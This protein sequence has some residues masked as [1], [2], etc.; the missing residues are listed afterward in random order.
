MIGGDSGFAGG[1]IS[2]G[3]TSSATTAAIGSSLASSFN[4]DCAW[5]A[6]VALARKRSTNAVSRRRS[7]LLLLGELEIERLALA[8]LALEGGVAA[9][10]ERELA[11]FEMQDPVD[12]VVEQ[13][14]V[15]ADDDHRAR[16][17]RDVLLEPK[18]RLEVEIV[19][20]L[21][22]QQQIGLGEQHR[23]ER[24]AHAPA[25]GEFRASAALLG[26]GETQAGEDFGGARRRRMGPDI[27]EPGLDLGDAVGIVLGLGLGQQSR[28]LGV[29]LE[30]DI[31][32]AFGAIRRL[33]G[34]A[35][36]AGAQWKRDL[37]VLGRELAADD[38][39]Q[40]GLPRAVAADE[41]D[42]GAVRNPC[43][44]AVDQQPAGQAHREVVD[45]E[46]ARGCGRDRS[47]R[48]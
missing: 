25:A 24:H 39:E 16:V 34:E 40:R 32:Q 19:G 14:A 45:H 18:R 47:T 43:R 9:A 13:I 35:A 27:G 4:R 26:M 8:A 31:E 2:I 44:C 7:R 48:Q 29:G 5:R 22:E 23:G 42:A 1:G 15:M 21:V 3:R 11:G 36:D 41:P 6:L 10:V 20:G 17:A 37:A 28:A 12:R 30:H 46:H 38:A 33:L